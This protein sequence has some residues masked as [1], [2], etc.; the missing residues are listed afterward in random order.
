MERVPWWKG[1]QIE[2]I[3]QD[4][5]GLAT[6]SIPEIAHK[7]NRWGHADLDIHKVGGSSAG[8]KS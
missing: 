8:V 4:K 3:V 2:P 1:S 7:C 6:A 5:D